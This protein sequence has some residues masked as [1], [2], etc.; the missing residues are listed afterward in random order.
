M[1]FSG[2]NQHVR[3]H[4]I[5]AL[6]VSGWLFVFV[7]AAHANLWRNHLPQQHIR[8]IAFDPQNRILWVGSAGSG[9]WKYDGQR[10]ENINVQN[11]AGG[12]PSNN[13]NALAVDDCDTSLWIGTDRGL[14]RFK[15]RLN[16][17]KTFRQDSVVSDNVK[18]VY[19]DQRC[20]LWYG[21]RGAGLGKFDGQ[22]WY[23]YDTRGYYLWNMRLSQWDTLKRYAVN[24]GPASN[25]INTI[26][27]DGRGKKY[28]G[29]ADNGLCILDHTDTLWTCRRAGDFRY[30]LNRIVEAI[31]IDR[32]EHKW[33]GTQGGI[34]ELDAADRIVN[35]YTE[36][37]SGLSDNLVCA[38]WIDEFKNKW[39]GTDNSGI[40]V[41]DSTATRWQSFPAEILGLGPASNQISAIAGDTDGNIWFGF[42]KDRGVSQYNNKWSYL[43]EKDGLSHNLVFAVESDSLGRLW[44]GTA[45]RGIEVFYRAGLAD[46]LKW[47]YYR[48]SCDWPDPVMRNPF[49]V[50]TILQ[51]EGKRMWVGTQACGLF[52]M[53]IAGSNLI[54]E[55]AYRRDKPA[56][57][58]TNFISCLAAQ[59]DTALW[60]GTDRGLC[61]L[62][63]DSALQPA[64]TDTFLL[65]DLGLSNVIKALV[66]DR[67]R[68]HLWAGTSNGLGRYDGNAWTL[69]KS[70]LPDIRVTAL[71][72]D[73]SGAI[74]VGTQGGMARFFNNQWKIFTTSDNL[75]DDNITVI[76]IDPQRT[77][78]CGTTDG[79]ASF[80]STNNAW[81]DYTTDD[82]LGDNFI[83]DITLAPQN[84]IWFST[85]GGGLT[86][87]H[88]TV[89]GPETQIV[90][91]LDVTFNDQENFEFIGFD[92]NT[93]ADQMQYSYKLD[94][95]P[96]SKPT[97]DRIVPLAIAPAGPHAFSVRAIDKDGN[98]DPSPSRRRFYKIDSHRGGAV[99]ITDSSR[100]Q[101]SGSLRLY[102]PPAALPSGAALRIIAVDTA[103]LQLRDDEKKRFTGMAYQLEPA[104]KTAKPLTLKIFYGEAIVEKFE[105]RTLA[106]YRRDDQS[107]SRLGGTVDTKQHCI[108][109]TIT[110]LGTIGL[111]IAAESTHH[112]AAI[113]GINL[114]AQPRMF[115]PR[116]NGFAENVTISFDLDQPTA[117]KMKV[118][119]L[120]GRLVKVLCENEMMNAG[121]NAVH[122]EGDDYGRNKCPSGMYLICLEAAG[123]TATKTVMV[124]N[125]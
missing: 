48:P 82:G 49:N 58:P 17:W 86:R 29:T 62:A 117:V 40:S 109:T 95:G 76:A 47:H 87:Y 111:F 66:L 59:K 88:K 10:F 101:K 93:P 38:I 5:L 30:P 19:V 108:T 96:W 90:T 78:W 42:F 25:F 8:A 98:V 83:T 45:G 34:C 35:Y 20:V 102:V 91:R 4:A 6:A 22:N 74:W 75:P 120:A 39:I 94:F 9:L 13:I 53:H 12:L 51:G 56:R 3:R 80:D 99:T 105:A 57:L 121:R 125:Q 114:A 92:L 2:L 43:T 41:L 104:I 46:S 116:G 97:S 84:V 44:A 68:N 52:A 24:E 21:T 119:N 113:T 28:F 81:I 65:A 73:S 106:V 70:V 67:R 110:E 69:Y 103:A 23:R 11:S 14:A 31:A 77:V 71:G 89:L 18:T 63:L 115:S 85:L 27:G 32:N 26:T 112:P 79:A 60:I 16:Q 122:W 55:K 37:P 123:K 50:T 36:S 61:R 124:V 118:Y 107:W 72:I 33:L 15:P 64:K 54:I 1:R 100:A 7:P